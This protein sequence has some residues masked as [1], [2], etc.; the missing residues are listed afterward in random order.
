MFEPGNAASLAD[1][2]QLLLSQ[3]QAAKE[4]TDTAAALLAD[5]YTWDAIATSTLKVYD[6]ARS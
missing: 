2:I 6:I 1:R 5:R 3:P 4:M